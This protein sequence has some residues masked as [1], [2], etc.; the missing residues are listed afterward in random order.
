MINKELVTDLRKTLNEAQDYGQEA[1][2]NVKRANKTGD[3]HFENEAAIFATIAARRANAF[4]QHA[5]IL[6]N[7]LLEGGY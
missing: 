4:L 3:V 1:L 6:G 7:I 2:V 5:T